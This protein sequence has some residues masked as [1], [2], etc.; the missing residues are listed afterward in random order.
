[1]IA[2]GQYLSA[3]VALGVIPA[4]ADPCDRDGAETTLLT[5]TVWVGLVTPV[6]SS[7]KFRLYAEIEKVSGV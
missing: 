4:G 5:V 7:P 1:V 6:C 2:G 3:I